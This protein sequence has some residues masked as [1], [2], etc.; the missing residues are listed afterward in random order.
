[1][2]EHRRRPPPA[3]T[4]QPPVARASDRGAAPRACLRREL[5]TALRAQFGRAY[6]RGH[7][8]ASTRLPCRQSTRSGHNRLFVQPHSCPLSA[9]PQAQAHEYQHGDK[10]NQQDRDHG[11]SARPSPMSCNS[12]MITSTAISTETTCRSCSTVLMRSLLRPSDRCASLP[13]SNRHRLCAL[14]IARCRSRY[15]ASGHTLTPVLRRTF[16]NAAVSSSV[17]LLPC[18]SGAW[19]ASLPT[20]LELTRWFGV[21]VRKNSAEWMR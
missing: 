1:V 11:A 20:V 21:G 5:S 10:Q 6:P 2:A 16:W 19:R 18:A 17:E 4:E 15:Q 3:G 8:G 12:S 13:R 9:A 7:I 14:R